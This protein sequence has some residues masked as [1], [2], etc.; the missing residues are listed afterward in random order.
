M[1][2]SFQTGVVTMKVSLS[3]LVPAVIY[4]D[5]RAIERTKWVDI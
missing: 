1:I 4:P 5:K 3:F 2:T